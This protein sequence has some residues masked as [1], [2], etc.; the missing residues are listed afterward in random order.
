MYTSKG[1]ILAAS[2]PSTV[3]AQAVGANNTVLTADT[4]QTRGIKWVQVGDAMILAGSNLAKLSAVTGTPTGTKLFRDDGSWQN[5]VDNMIAA[6]TNLAKLAAVT[7]TPSGSKFLRDDGSWQVPAG[8]GSVSAQ[9]NQLAADV[10]VT[11]ANQWYDGPQLSLVAGSYLLVAV[12]TIT[13][14]G[15]GTDVYGRLWD[16]TTTVGTTQARAAG[17]VPSMVTLVGIATLGATATWRAAAAC[18]AS[19]GAIKA[20]LQ[21]N[22]VGNTASTLVAVKYA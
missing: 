2:A 11:N 18:S 10:T 6:G 3:S 4:G 15:S 17:A 13:P 5:V 12:L 7:G 21:A 9:M 8:G 22:A 1:A 20:Q 16:G 14:G 19:G